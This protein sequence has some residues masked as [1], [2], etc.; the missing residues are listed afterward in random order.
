MTCP[1][2]EKTVKA[3]NEGK[4]RV[5]KRLELAA[6]EEGLYIAIWKHKDVLSIIEKVLV[7]Q[8]HRRYQIKLA[9][10]W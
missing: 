5:G 7:E 6:E 4:N 8:R 2:C 10:S 1:V 9:G 3:A